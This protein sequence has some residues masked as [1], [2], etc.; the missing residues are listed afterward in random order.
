M[1]HLF[2]DHDKYYIHK[3]LGV[4]CLLNFFLRFGCILCYDTAFPEWD[5][6][7]IASGFTI[8]SVCLHG[9]LSCSSLIFTLPQKRNESSPMIWPEFRL[10][11][12]LFATRH[13]IGTLLALLELWSS[14]LIYRVI[15]KIMFII[16]VN[17][18]AKCVTYFKG[19]T[20]KRT[21]NAMP[22]PGSVGE[23]DKDNIKHQYTCAQF[24]ATLYSV[25]SDPTFTFMPLLGIQIAPLLMTL[26]R[27]GK[28]ASVTY[29]RIYA[30]AL[31][32]PYCIVMLQLYR[33]TLNVYQLVWAGI[34]SNKICKG[35]RQE[36]R[37]P[38]EIVW[39]IGVC[40][41]E[42][43]LEVLNISINTFIDQIVCSIVVLCMV[44]KPGYLSLI[45]SQKIA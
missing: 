26:I 33:N 39:M 14:S 28:I 11:S 34:V 7:L 3:S 21:T 13:V 30:L 2:T 22:Y 32:L 43:L 16:I 12:I 15:Q 31:F 19:N 44:S 10:H 9:L 45:S 20:E 1:A 41:Y 4:L 29:H 24:L 6:S 38:V 40:L 23:E 5:S 42:P 35:L 37:V 27:K 8:S 18:L 17:V 25:S 36:Y